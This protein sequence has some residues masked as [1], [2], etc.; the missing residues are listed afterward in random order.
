MWSG[1]DDQPREMEAARTGEQW[2][3]LRFSPDGHRLAAD[4]QDGVW[5]WTKDRTGPFL[6][7]PLKLP[8]GMP[9]KLAW[10]PDGEAIAL[11]SNVGARVV[12]LDG[13]VVGSF[14]TPGS[15]LDVA[16][17][18]AGDA[19]AI[20]GHDRAG[21]R[22]YSPEG[23]HL[24][25]LGGP[26]SAT[27]S[28]DWCTDGTWIA[29]GEAAC[30]V[31]VWNAGSG[32]PE[33]VGLQLPDLKNVSFTAAG[34]IIDGEMDLLDRRLIC[35][36]E[37]DIGQ[38]ELVKPSEFQQRSA[39]DW[40]VDSPAPIDFANERAVA[41]WVQN[42]GGGLQWHLADNPYDTV[43][44]HWGDELKP[45]PEG[46]F[47]VRTVLLDGNQRVTS[48]DLRQLTSLAELRQ[49]NLMGA[50]ID[51]GAM[52]HIA[53]CRSLQMLYLSGPGVTSAAT[54]TL[55]ELPLQ[56]MVMHG[57][58]LTQ[59]GLDDISQ[60][61]SLTNLSIAS[62]DL[63]PLDL[64][65]LARIPGLTDLGIHETNV[66]DEDLPELL[67][68]PSLKGLHLGKTRITDAAL[69]M[70]AQLNQLQSLRLNHNPAI[71][72][73]A[74]ETL[75]GMTGLDDLHIDHTG[76]TP[77]GVE[78]LH[79]AL[80]DCAILWDGGVITRFNP[81]KDREVAEWVHARGELLALAVSHW[82]TSPWL[83]ENH[84][85]TSRLHSSHSTCSNSRS[86]M[87]IWRNWMGCDIS[88]RSFST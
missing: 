39:P 12:Q 70:L 87:L 58:G 30:V 73:A 6:A 8:V 1:N 44:G 66:G 69:A 84:C 10:R 85:R 72:D 43:E 18:P 50:A 59:E 56:S 3:S 75:T 79:L 11:V 29:A 57:V 4:S 16:W 61:S 32:E 68:L 88:P 62:N 25:S 67:V 2:I 13:T 80:P 54:A 27:Y 48:D 22:L 65:V 42:I 83:P 40:R 9:G 49:L 52:P 64:S 76:I 35:L 31:H 26:L 77:E 7:D 19:L 71:T 55:V 74:V 46:P 15:P 86:P 53:G 47:T 51:D 38:I 60:I 63:A 24:A 37:S 41:G 14:K 81:A 28:V 33:W 20:A 17:S 45:L 23:T 5:I 82:L 34:Q 36:V 21:V 78:R